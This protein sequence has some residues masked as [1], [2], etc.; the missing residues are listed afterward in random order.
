LAFFASSDAGILNSERTDN[1]LNDVDINV[2]G[3]RLG[4]ISTSWN[5]NLKYIFKHKLY[6]Q[7]IQ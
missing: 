3:N 1:H 2:N 4:R 7:I 5:S 6:L